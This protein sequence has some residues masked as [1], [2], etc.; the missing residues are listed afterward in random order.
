MCPGCGR[1]VYLH[2]TLCTRCG[3]ELYYPETDEEIVPP[4]LPVSG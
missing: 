2:E 4:E 3:T 1:I